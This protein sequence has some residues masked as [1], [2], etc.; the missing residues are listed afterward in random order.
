RGDIRLL[1][2]LRLPGDVAFIVGGILPLLYLALRMVA[3]RKRPG[4]IAANEQ[5]EQLTTSSAPPPSR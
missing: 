2:W 5:T 4:A 1:E 3:N